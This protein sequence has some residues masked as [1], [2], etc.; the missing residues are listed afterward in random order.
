MLDSIITNSDRTAKN[1]NLLNW[2]NELWLIDHGAS[3]YF[4]H[5]WD[6]WRSHLTRT[7][8]IIKDHVLLSRADHLMESANEIKTL[9]NED[10]ITE[11]VSLIPEGWLL[12]ESNTLSPDEMRAAYIEFLVSR[13]NQIDVLAKE[14]NDAK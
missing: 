11:I 7:F 5:N 13:L 9:L 4:H 8:P 10:K 2:N 3:L 1:T 14:A 12:D 6:H